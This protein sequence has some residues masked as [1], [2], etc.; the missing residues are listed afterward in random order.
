MTTYIYALCHPTTGEIRYIGKSDNPERRLREHLKTALD[1]KV[2][3]HNARW[4]RSLR[5]IGEA[6]K[7]RTLCAV[8][9][10]TLWPGY[11]QFF[12]ASARYLGAR[13]TNGTVGGD[14]AK[15]TDPDAIR[16]KNAAV[17]AAMSDPEVLRKIS[18]A[19]SASYD[20]NGRREQK[21]AES[22]AMWRDPEYAARVR[23]KMKETNSLPEVKEKRSRVA[24]ETVN[25][26]EVK[27]KLAKR[28]RD[29][30]QTPEGRAHRAALLVN[31]NHVERKKEAAKKAW[32][33]EEFKEKY[34][35]AKMS[36]EVSAKQASAS[37]AQWSDPEKRQ[38]IHGALSAAWA[39]PEKRAAR[40]AKR[41]ATIAAKKLAHQHQTCDNASN[42]KER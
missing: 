41:R 31:E 33:G 3:H 2:V 28:T 6:P 14:G 30:L 32:Q 5:A 19:V 1:A 25:R 10:R 42:V 4:V 7:L 37:I 15:L 22:T 9:D 23:L 24:K 18:K 26:P 36:P 16:R 8:S 21:R 20:K 35:V 34:W 27:A 13:L 40:L 38:R 11:E 12:I 29:W 17:A 39:D